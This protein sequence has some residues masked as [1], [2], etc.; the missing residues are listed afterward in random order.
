MFLNELIS[1][2][3]QACTSLELSNLLCS[4]SDLLTSAWVFASACSTLRNTECTEADK[5]N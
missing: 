1:E 4:D 2:L 5:L 3:D